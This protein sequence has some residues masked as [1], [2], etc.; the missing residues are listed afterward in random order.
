MPVS[1]PLRNDDITKLATSKPGERRDFLT[2]F[3]VL[4]VLIGTRKLSL[5][6]FCSFSTIE[7]T[8]SNSFYPNFFQLLTISQ[9]TNRGRRPKLS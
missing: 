8:T 9:R 7:T 1:S 4:I 2:S 5:S 3:F 6:F